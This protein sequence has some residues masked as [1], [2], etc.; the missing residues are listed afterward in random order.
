MGCAIISRLIPNGF[1]GHSPSNAVC[2]LKLEEPKSGFRFQGFFD[3]YVKSDWFNDKDEVCKLNL[4][5]ARLLAKTIIDRDCMGE[6]EIYSTLE[7]LR[8]V[9]A[10]LFPI[11]V[12]SKTISEF[13]EGDAPVVSLYERGFIHPVS[14]V[15]E[16]LTKSGWKYRE[17]VLKKWV[18][19]HTFDDIGELPHLYSYDFG[20]HRCRF[21]K[22][23]LLAGSGCSAEPPSL[24]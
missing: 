5:D 7:K 21:F 14:I 15:Y 9:G 13:L 1:V 23:E 10:E 16:A 20:A 19:T 12:E 4:E 3:R 22:L 24:A 8:A 17:R 6:R 18:E 2:L 11:D